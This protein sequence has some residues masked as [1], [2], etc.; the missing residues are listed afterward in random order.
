MDAGD[1][2]DDAVGWWM[3]S[4]L[5]NELVGVLGSICSELPLLMVIVCV[6]V[7]YSWWSI[8]EDPRLEGREF[9]PNGLLKDPI[10][11]EL[12]DDIEPPK[13]LLVLGDWESW[14][15]LEMDE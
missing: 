9:P 1:G 5:S 3:L 2:M 12:N 8:I 6:G 10:L 4:L 7:K 15:L 11:N 13:V 14:E